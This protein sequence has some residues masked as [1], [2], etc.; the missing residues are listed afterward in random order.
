VKTAQREAGC[1]G[2]CDDEITEEAEGKQRCPTCE[3]DGSKP[4]EER[5]KPKGGELL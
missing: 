3:K 2:K 4:K 5:K 1:S